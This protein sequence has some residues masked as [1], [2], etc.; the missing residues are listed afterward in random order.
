[1]VVAPKVLMG[2]AMHGCIF[3]KSQR[4]QRYPVHPKI[5]HNTK[6][7]LRRLERATSATVQFLWAEIIINYFRR[8]RQIE[9]SAT[10]QF[11]KAETTKL[12]P[13]FSAR[14]KSFA[15]VTISTFSIPVES[16][17]FVDTA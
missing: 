9:E 7:L 2:I 6:A 8:S 13:S 10:V 12:L 16:N 4:T 11:L 5:Q 3:P 17:S 1:V 15:I 14:L